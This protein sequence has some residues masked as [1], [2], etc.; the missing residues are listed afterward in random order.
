MCFRLCEKGGSVRAI[1]KVTRG[2]RYMPPD[3]AEKIAFAM[4]TPPTQAPHHVLSQ[5]ELEVLRLLA[6]GKPQ[7]DRGPAL[8]ERK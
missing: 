7:R 4:A 3:L 6:A 5:R 2:G 8:A 1:Q